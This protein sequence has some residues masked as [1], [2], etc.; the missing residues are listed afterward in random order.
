MFFRGSALNKKLRELNPSR[1]IFKKAKIKHLNFNKKK[2]T[3][4]N[5]KIV[6]NVTNTGIALKHTRPMVF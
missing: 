5:F 6:P 2:I 4:I 1:Q 3:L